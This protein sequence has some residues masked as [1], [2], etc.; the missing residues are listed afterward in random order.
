M[1][2]STARD[3]TGTPPLVVVMGV[4]GCGKSY[5][6]ERLAQRCSV[7][8]QD[9]DD[10]HPPANIAKMRAGV[11]LTDEDREPWLHAV[12]RW[13]HEHD[14]AGGVVA[15]SALR[16]AYR[17]LLRADAP[18]ATFLHLTADPAVFRER[19][20]GRRHFMP[21]TLLDS[22]LATLEPLEPDERGVAVDATAPVGDI[23]DRFLGS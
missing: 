17:D 8:Y 11:P 10:L 6:G 18:R 16:R 22:Q 9:G 1:A 20:R 3:G 13:L 2:P 21:T 23:L 19:M 12:A 14:A 5:V 7:A 15:C 4:S